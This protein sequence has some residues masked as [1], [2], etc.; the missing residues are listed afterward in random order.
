MWSPKAL[1]ACFDCP[2]ALRRRRAFT[3]FVTPPQTTQ[4]ARVF[5]FARYTPAN[6]YYRRVCQCAS[7]CNKSTLS[8]LRA[9]LGLVEP[10]YKQAMKLLIRQARWK[11]MEVGK[12]SIADCRSNQSLIAEH[13]T[14]AST[15][16]TCVCSR[17]HGPFCSHQS[18]LWST[19]SNWADDD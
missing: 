16:N 2:C 18:R 5:L 14:S 13:R 15:G 4:F 10:Q 3:A 12:H 17:E 7:S 11:Y 19:T 9:V 1:F 8:A 6:K